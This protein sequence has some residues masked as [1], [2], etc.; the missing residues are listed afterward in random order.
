MSISKIKNLS[1]I[2]KLKT[3][4]PNGGFYYQLCCISGAYY[5]LKLVFVSKYYFS[6]FKNLQALSSNDPFGFNFPHTLSLGSLFA[7]GKGVGGFGDTFELWLA[8]QIQ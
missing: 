4:C 7:V 1:D 8:L 3:G 6:I 2:I 5:L